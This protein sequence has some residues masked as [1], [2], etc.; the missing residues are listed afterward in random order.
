[1][2]NQF[3]PSRT[4]H[5]ALVLVIL[6]IRSLP[7]SSSLYF[8]ADEKSKNYHSRNTKV[9]PVLS[10]G[11]VKIGESRRS[12]IDHLALKLNLTKPSLTSS[13]LSGKIIFLT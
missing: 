9:A 7:S 12:L 6:Q 3:T 1:M 11:E 4:I 13:S 10:S 2:P 8:K 5:C